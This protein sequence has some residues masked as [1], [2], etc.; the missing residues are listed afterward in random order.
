MATAVERSA[1]AGAGGPERSAGPT[2]LAFLGVA[3]PT[4]MSGAILQW[5]PFATVNAYPGA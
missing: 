5:V 2:A 1:A 4:K 3:E